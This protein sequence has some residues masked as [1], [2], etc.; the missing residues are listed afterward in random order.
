[1]EGHV[2]GAALDVFV[3]EPVEAENPLLKLDNV[4]L[5]PHL[6]AS[7]AEAQERVAQEIAEQVVE[8]LTEGTIRNAVNVPALPGE[9]AQKSRRTSRSAASWASCSASSSRSTCASCA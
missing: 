6:G 2:A 3:K 5:T 9:A 4:V 1:M 8:Y 7:T